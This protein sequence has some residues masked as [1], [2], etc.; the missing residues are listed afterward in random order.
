MLI[1]IKMPV[2]LHEK[3]TT[4]KISNHFETEDGDPKEIVGDFIE[5][6]LGHSYFDFT[7]RL[8]HNKIDPITLFDCPLVP[9]TLNLSALSIELCKSLTG[10]GTL[11]EYS[12]LVKAV[13][14][15]NVVEYG[16]CMALEAYFNNLEGISKES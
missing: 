2:H 3:L 4:D 5:W 12:K 13:G 10:F 7:G 15:D 9:I 1:K 11:S 16:V 14:R 6:I 8:D